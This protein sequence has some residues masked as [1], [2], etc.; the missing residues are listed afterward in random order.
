MLGL[1]AAGL[2]AQVIGQPAGHRAHPRLIFG[3]HP[4]VVE[5]VAQVRR[6]LIGGHL[7]PGRPELDVDPGLG[8]LTAARL[9][10]V[11]VVAADAQDAAQ[12]AGHVP[13][14]SQQRVHEQF[15]LGL[16]PVQ[17]GG[18]RVDQVG[19]VV[20]DDVH[21]QAG[22]ADGAEVSLS[23]LPDLDQ[24]PALRPTQAEPGVRFRHHGQPRRRSQVLGGHAL[25]VSAQVAEDAVAAAPVVQRPRVQGGIVP[26]RLARLD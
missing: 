18:D 17:F 15:D 4:Y 23:R 21:D 26:P 7:V 6:E 11:G 25:V 22:P 8:Q 12:R 14:H 13:V 5:H 1:V 9:V 19:H 2:P 20:G 3:R 16:V 24:R 10:L